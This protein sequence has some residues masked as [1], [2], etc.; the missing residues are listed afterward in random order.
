VKVQRRS[1]VFIILYYTDNYVFMISTFTLDKSESENNGI[2]IY[3]KDSYF[4]E[5]IEKVFNIEIDCC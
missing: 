5:N 4:F 2:I 3:I 1:I